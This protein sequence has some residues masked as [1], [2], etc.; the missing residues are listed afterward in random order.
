MIE[1]AEILGRGLIRVHD[2]LIVHV[3]VV[4]QGGVEVVVEVQALGPVV[5]D[6]NRLLPAPLLRHGGKRFRQGGNG[7]LALVI[8][9]RVV[10][11][12]VPLG[13]HFPG[14]ILFPLGVVPLYGLIQNHAAELSVKGLLKSGAHHAAP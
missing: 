13:G 6:G 11:L 7:L 14:D 9:V 1:P 10:I 12:P 8:I 4:G 2:E 5:R 3:E